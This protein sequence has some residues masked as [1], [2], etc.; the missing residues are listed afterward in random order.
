MIETLAARVKQALGEQE[1]AAALLGD[2]RKRYPHSRALLYAHV[3]RAAR[4]RPRQGRARP[5]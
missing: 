3:A 2:A 4:R 5:R 1:R